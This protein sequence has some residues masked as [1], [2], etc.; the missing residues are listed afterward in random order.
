MMFKFINLLCWCLIA[1]PKLVLS[2][3]IKPTL[4]KNLSK[5]VLKDKAVKPVRWA[6][7]KAE[8]LDLREKR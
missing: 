1:F 3:E 2:I 5:E 7:R 8:Q 6:D 4:D